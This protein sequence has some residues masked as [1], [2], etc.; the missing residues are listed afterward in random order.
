[1]FTCS[2][3]MFPCTWCASVTFLS[4]LLH[5]LFPTFEPSLTCSSISPS[6]FPSS[7]SSPPH[8]LFLFLFDS[9]LYL[10]PF[11]IFPIFLLLSLPFLPYLS[12]FFYSCL[13]HFLSP[14]LILLSISSSQS[15]LFLLK[16]SYFFLVCS[17]TSFSFL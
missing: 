3:Y 12:S 10:S 17:L 2:Y 8:L 16:C 13:L 9:S 15:P 5:L 14:S 7:S 11:L 1:M 6:S 4:L